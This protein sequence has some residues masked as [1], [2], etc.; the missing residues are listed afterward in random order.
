MT[1]DEIY[2]NSFN[3]LAVF[4]CQRVA[5]TP[6]KVNNPL[7]LYGASGAG[8]TMLLQ[9]IADT[10][11]SN[12]PESRIV[13]VTAG[14]LL[15]ELVEA[16]QDGGI[17]AME[18]RYLQADYVLID[19]LELLHGKES[20]TAYI[21][22]LVDRLV[23]EGKQVVLAMSAVAEDAFRSK[24]LGGLRQK[25]K[26]GFLVDIQ[27][28]SEAERLEF[29]LLFVRQHKF[30]LSEAVC[31]LIAAHTESFRQIIGAVTTLS[32]HR[33]LLSAAPPLATVIQALTNKKLCP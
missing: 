12:N 6:H 16:L 19:M 33:E 25:Y 1:F 7:T 8:K 5:E 11:R 20:S 23:A 4:L 14:A 21:M 9:A 27:P 17:E 30:P 18:Q 2:V 15:D 31:T 28:P 32:A 22:R 24:T 13:F 29:T 3:R 26:D 10:A